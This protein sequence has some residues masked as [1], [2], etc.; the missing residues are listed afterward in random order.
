MTVWW[1]RGCGMEELQGG[2]AACPS[3]GAALQS[4]DIDWLNENDKGP[5]TVFEIETTSV[6]RAAIVDGLMSQSI[7]HRWEGTQD[8]VVADSDGDAVDSI[9]DA[10]LGEPDDDED[11]DDFDDND[12]EDD[13]DD[14]DFE[15]ADGYSTL[16]RLFV[17][18]D[19]LFKNL[20]SED[21]VETFS[22]ATNEVLQTA[23]PFG[24]EAEEWA[25]IQST[26]RNISVQLA[27]D[28]KAPVAADLKGLHN[29]LQQ[30]V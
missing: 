14:E 13:D 30:L 25:D 29:Q 27:T 19:K 11:D 5:E 18:T 16:S 8:L 7:R 17:A 9:L 20:S 15:E 28:A 26:A 3:C 12:D 2:R 24:V 1:C 22:E 4:A 6:E 23:T 10:V 21:E